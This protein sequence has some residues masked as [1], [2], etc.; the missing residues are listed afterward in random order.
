M[1]FATAG[2]GLGPRRHKATPQPG[3]SAFGFRA[4]S[5]VCGPGP[6]RGPF[7][8]LRV[9][10]CPGAPTPGRVPFGAGR[11]PFVRPGFPGPPAS[12]VGPCAPLC[13]SVAAPWGPF[14]FG[15]PSLRFGLPLVALA[16]SP[17]SLRFSGSPRRDPPGAPFGPSLRVGPRAVGSAGLRPRGLRRP[18]AA[19]FW[20][21]APG[22]F[23]LRRRLLPPC[24]PSPG[25]L[26]VSG[27]LPCAPRPPPPLG[28][29]GARRPVG[30]FAPASWVGFLP[31]LLRAPRRA[32]PAPGAAFS[33]RLTVRKLSTGF[34]SPPPVPFYRAR[35]G[36][37]L[38]GLRSQRRRRCGA[39]PGLDCPG[40]GNLPGGLDFLPVSWYSSFP[41]PVA[42]TSVG[43]SLS[44]S[45]PGEKP[46]L[47]FD[48]AGLFL[49]PLPV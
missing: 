21:S 15:S 18:S 11:P 46:R 32:P 39:R 47:V 40:A 42:L 41:A 10:C 29:P 38:A 4:T 6:L 5:S 36:F 20:P 44:V 28:A 14:P 37:P 3:P 27:V 16:P 9:P 45:V 30:G 22:P 43:R 19:L 33:A 12:S 23:F 2:S 34:A 13:G 24:F 25:V 1:P 8:P 31:P 7:C 49:R 17:A 48:Q 26:C 35:Q